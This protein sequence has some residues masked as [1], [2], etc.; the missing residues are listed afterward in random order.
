MSRIL[1]ACHRL[2][3]SDLTSD[4]SGRYQAGDA[5]GAYAPSSDPKEVKIDDF[6]RDVARELNDQR[7]K[8]GYEKL[9][10]IAP[11][12]QSG[13]LMHHMDKHVKDL[14]I[15]NIQKDLLH[16]KAKDLLTIL[17]KTPNY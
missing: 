2:H 10:L 17:E 3:S 8:N 9:I 12:Q 14:I 11:S 7:N 4:R 1:G 6:L 5:H 16:L 15:S 13:I